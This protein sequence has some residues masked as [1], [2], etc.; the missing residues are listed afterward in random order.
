[1]VE[2]LAAR[3]LERVD[4]AALRVDAGHDV[5]DRAVLAGRVHRLEDGQHRPA[6][7]R[8]EHVLQLGERL[9]AHRQRLLRARLV[10]VGVRCSVS[11]G[12]TSARRKRRPSVMRK[13]FARLRAP[14]VSSLMSMT[15]PRSPR[16]AARFRPARTR[17]E[18]VPAERPP[19]SKSQRRTFR[20]MRVRQ[21]PLVFQVRAALTP[22]H[23]RRAAP[24][25][26]SPASRRRSGSG[27]LRYWTAG[28]RTL[29]AAQLGDDV[30]LDRQT[31][32]PHQG[33]A[34]EEGRRSAARRGPRRG[35]GRR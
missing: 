17:L 21:R 33:V 22:S 15:S 5:L 3:R 30:A 18:C 16:T 13:G 1:M 14:L 25:P 24:S 26:A 32:E 10:L 6:V 19:F 8:V 27:S 28:T 29:A 12:S 35:A 23:C 11:P 2:I 31:V 20:R 4:L 7:L 9:D 34:D